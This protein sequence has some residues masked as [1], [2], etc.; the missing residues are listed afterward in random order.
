MP[1]RIRPAMRRRDV[2]QSG[3]IAAGCLAAPAIVRAQSVRPAAPYGVQVGD[4]VGDRAIVWSA[5]DRPAGCG[6]GGRPPRA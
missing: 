1:V 4:V 3:A 6:C 5:A 2:L